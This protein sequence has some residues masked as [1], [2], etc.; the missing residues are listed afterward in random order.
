[1]NVLID[2]NVVL[3]LLLKREPY[4]MSA[5]KISAL[6]EKG[7]INGYISASAV[8]DIYYIANKELKSKE[9]VLE[10]LE[11]LL[12]TTHVAAITESSIY[13]ALSLKWDD[14]EDSVQYVAGTSISAEFM[15]TRNPKD[16]IDSQ[17]VVVSPNEFLNRITTE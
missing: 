4:Y 11:S 9:V 1:M 17:V 6:S 12:K 15:I 7:Y 16:Y 8:T 5:A 3:D 10:L 2:T 14:F 13:E